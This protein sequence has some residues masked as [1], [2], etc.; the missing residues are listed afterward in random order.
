MDLR[1]GKMFT[2]PRAEVDLLFSWPE[3]LTKF[4][5]QYVEFKGSSRGALSAGRLLSAS[6]PPVNAQY[7]AARKSSM[8]TLEAPE[9]G[10]GELEYKVLAMSPPGRSPT[11]DMEPGLPTLGALEEARSGKTQIKEK[12]LK[13]YREV[14]ALQERAGRWSRVHLVAVMGSQYMAGMDRGAKPTFFVPQDY[15]L[16]CVKL[17][18]QRGA[19]MP[20]RLSEQVALVDVHG[21]EH[22][23][24]G[25]VMS[26]SGPGGIWSEI[27]YTADTG[28]IERSGFNGYPEKSSAPAGSTIREGVLLFLIPQTEGPLGVIGMRVRQG[29]RDAG[30]MYTLGGGVDVVLPAGQE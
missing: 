16:T 24:V 6:G 23:P 15:S 9:V 18:S 19:S 26:L 20:S 10:G 4:V 11:G 28:R 21:R 25:Y 13:A 3:S 8:V 12:D 22:R 17:Q 29:A 7:A 14:E 2:S 30:A 1:S 27:A 5:P